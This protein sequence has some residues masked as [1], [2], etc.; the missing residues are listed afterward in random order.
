MGLTLHLG[1]L[2]QPYRAVPNKPRRGAGARI[3]ALTTGDVA[4]FLEQKYGIMQ[5]FIDAHERDIEA[6]I[7]KSIEN[8]LESLL[9]GRVR[10][11]AYAG[12]TQ[13]IETLF[14][15]FIATKEVEGLNI[16]GVPTAAA[17]RGVNHRLA[18]PFRKSN[19][20]RPSF[21]DTGLYLASFRCWTEAK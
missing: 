3:S 19:P 5:R 1:V 10:I 2:E 6:A 7:E 13:K 15:D 4:V 20:R 21:V 8:S 12:A 9:T 16:P 17:M 11:N 18:H 14:R